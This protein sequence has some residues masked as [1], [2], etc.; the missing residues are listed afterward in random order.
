MLLLAAVSLSILLFI[1]N[2]PQRAP[3]AASEGGASP[4]LP[5]PVLAANAPRLEPG[6][7]QRELEYREGLSET[8]TELKQG[9][10]LG[11]VLARL[12]LQQTEAHV[13]SQAAGEVIDLT[14]V[15]PGA[16]ITLYRDKATGRP[17]RLEYA[18]GLKPQVIMLRTPT[19]YAAARK[20]VAPI[21]C[22]TFTEGRIKSS[23][24]GSA[25]QG[26]K[27]DPELVLSFA[28]LFAFDIDF[29]TDVQ[30]GDSF[31]MLFEKEYCLGDS[32]GPGRIFAAEFVNQGKKYELFYYRNADGE[33]GYYDGKGNSRKKFFLAS[34]LQY[35]RISSH[36][37]R[38]R[39][40]PILKI[41]RPHLGVDYSAPTG[42]PVETV[43]SG[44]V[45]FV[46]WRAVTAGWW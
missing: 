11:H 41:R 34:P 43:A 2:G 8:R 24:W 10:T 21:K 40:H 37:S 1:Y 44:T 23:L 46:G 33:N 38:S 4:D 39:L 45:T 28:D 29:F 16:E 3:E 9:D 17:R 32:L 15:R 36:F 7:F 18:H 20:T 25:V 6:A 19:G 42:T 35:R 13:V 26:Y 27:L 22:L 14:R 30:S 12:G 5:K 31:G